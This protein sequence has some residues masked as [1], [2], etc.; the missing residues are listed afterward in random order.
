M[1]V[2]LNKTENLKNWAQN[3]KPFIDTYGETAFIFAPSV[4]EY[5]PDIY[6]WLQA[7]GYVDR[8]DLKSYL[9]AIQV[10]ED[11]Q[12]YFAIRDAEKEQLSK[13]FDYS[14]RSQIINR[15]ERDRRLLKQSNPLLESALN[16][17]EDKGMLTQRLNDLNAAITSPNTPISSEIRST[18]QIV[19]KE[20]A[21]MI[22]LDSNEYA[23]NSRDFTT[24]KRILKEEI[25]SV[26]G[27]L[28]AI[29]PEVK[30]AS[31]L[32]FIPLLNEYT[33]DVTSASPKG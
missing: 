17:S 15:A 9:K 23:R 13:A 16:S 25:L 14:E 12:M 26:I 24:Q 19:T 33:R 3:N 10:A 11:K 6:A 5:N 29:S 7:S 20:M 21:R 22:Q 8:V 28:A 32:I 2:F 30:E 1:R 27:D 18:L 4:G 31:R